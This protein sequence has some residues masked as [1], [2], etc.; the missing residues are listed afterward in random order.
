MLKFLSGS[1]TQGSADAFATASIATGLA[2]ASLGYR[3]RGI[4]FQYPS[5]VE[6]DNFIQLQL[7]RRIPTA[8]VADT[9]RTLIWGNTR[10]FG[11]TTSGVGYASMFDWFAFDRDLDLLIVEDP[12]YFSADS[13]GTSNADTFRVRV[14]YEEVRLSETAKLAALTE[15]LNA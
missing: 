12:I 5:F 6:A 3:V 11:I 14:Y 4:R 15:S 9:D 7:V 8:I 2:N 1:V 10:Q 13:N